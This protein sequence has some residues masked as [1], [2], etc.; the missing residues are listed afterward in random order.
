MSPEAPCPEPSLEHEFLTAIIRHLWRAGKYTV[1]VADA[2]LDE[3]DETHRL[4]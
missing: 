3:V 2:A 4:V 1:V